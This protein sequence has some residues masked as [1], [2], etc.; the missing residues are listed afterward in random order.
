MAGELIWSRAALDDLA[1]IAAFIA[2]D[3]RVQSRRVLEAVF[4][5]A[6]SLLDRPG[7]PQMAP[8]SGSEVVFEARIR[9]YRLLFERQGDDLHVLAI[10][11]GREPA[12][13]SSTPRQRH[14]S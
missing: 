4:A 12:A 3:S 13:D 14:Q 2:E 8:E 5:G 7:K 6:E 10:A 11:H 9:G 1:A